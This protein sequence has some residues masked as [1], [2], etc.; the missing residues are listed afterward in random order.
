MEQYPQAGTP[1]TAAG[2]EAAAAARAEAEGIS[3][4]WFL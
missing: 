1:L 3:L 4:I 2:Q